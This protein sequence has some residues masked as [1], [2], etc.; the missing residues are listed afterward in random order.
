[1]SS[2]AL[3]GLDTALTEIVDLQ[4]VN[5]TPT[6]AALSAPLITRAIGRA[7][8]VLLSSHF[9]RYIYAVNAEAA[10]A[11]SLSGA[12]GDALPEGLRL[13]HSRHPIDELA[14]TIWDRRGDALNKFVREESWL[15]VPGQG[16]HLEHK[17]LLTWMKAPFPKNLKRYYKEWGI[18]DIFSAI[19]R[20]IHTRI[21]LELRISELVGKRNG[22]AHGDFSVDATQ[23]DIRLYRAA[24]QVF[25]ERAD[26]ALSRQLATLT[27]SVPW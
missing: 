7:S 25:A 21:D 11:V 3:E 15:W 26:R 16:G 19:T 2:S 14:L 5:P 23:S 20:R 22:I 18:E 1:V 10:E 17:R 13:A 24:V 12:T 27:G 6:G 8:V 9:E 4:R